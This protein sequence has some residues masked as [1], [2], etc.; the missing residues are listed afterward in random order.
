M[1]NNKPRWRTPH[2]SSDTLQDGDRIVAICWW[3]DQ[4]RRTPK[5]HVVTLSVHEDGVVR[6]N[7][8][9]GL[10]LEDCDAWMPESEFVRLFGPQPQ[11]EA[12]P[13]SVP[14]QQADGWEGR[15]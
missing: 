10:C 1:S 15:Q 6:D 7:E 14:W 4:P 5:L 9:R 3:A 12:P 2:D 13:A 8:E 11:A